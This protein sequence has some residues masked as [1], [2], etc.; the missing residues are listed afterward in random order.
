M[1]C[2]RLGVD[3]D[4]TEANP[5]FSWAVALSAGVRVHVRVRVCSC[6]SNTQNSVILT[7]D[8][9]QVKGSGS[10]DSNSIRKNKEKQSTSEVQSYIFQ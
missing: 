1:C 7:K 9:C 2:Q 8:D 3:K 4:G 5:K 6:V 10:S